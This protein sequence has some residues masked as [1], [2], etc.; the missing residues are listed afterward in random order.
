MPKPSAEEEA[1]MRDGALKW[2][3]CMRDHGVDVPD[4]TFDGNGRSRV[5]LHSSSSGSDPATQSNGSGPGGPTMAGPK[6]DPKFQAA[7][8]ACQTKGGP[9][10]HTSTAK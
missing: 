4:P 6:D 3:K 9:G 7:M 10:I 5:E 8:K 2:A 1:K